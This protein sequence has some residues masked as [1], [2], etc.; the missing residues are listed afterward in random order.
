MKDGF[1][2]YKLVE[3]KEDLQELLDRAELKISPSYYFL[4]WPHKVSGIIQKLPDDFP[5]YEGQMFNSQFDLRWKKKG[6]GYEVLLLSIEPKNE[7]GFEEISGNKE[8]IK[9]E[10]IDRPAYFYNTGETR[11]PKGFIFKDESD[12]KIDPKNIAVGQR[13]F[14]DAKTAT[15]HFI[16]LTVGTEK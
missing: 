1:V 5:G 16:A 12:E 9:W 13:Y 7:L 15:V 6:T 3:S 14:Q 4:C 10:A 11:F 8:A 2:G